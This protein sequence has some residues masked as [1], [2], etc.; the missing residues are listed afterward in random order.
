MLSKIV[1]VRTGWQHRI[2][3]FFLFVSLE[4][5]Y[6][7]ALWFIDS[8]GAGVMQCRWLTPTPV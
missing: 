2:W 1:R 8:S 3:M 7:V 5:N 4:D 6:V